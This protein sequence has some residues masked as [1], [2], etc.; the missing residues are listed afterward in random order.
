MKQK[1]M[2]SP[3]RISAAELARRTERVRRIAR[4]L[5]FVGTV[6]YRHVASASG[7]ALY[8]QGVTTADDLLVVYARA[9]DRDA[10]PSDFSLGAI[11]AHERGHRL[12]ARH[13]SLA[14]FSRLATAVSEEVVASLIGA[15]IVDD[16]AD[17]ESLVGK[18]AADLLFANKHPDFVKRIIRD[19]SR[20]LK[21][22]L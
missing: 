12:F 14:A 7:G 18:A 6:E 22:V 15:R 5:G 9:F 13:P 2:K 21:E 20:T 16:P 11:I 10:D 1:R 4:S 17:R 19:V 8:G 3:K